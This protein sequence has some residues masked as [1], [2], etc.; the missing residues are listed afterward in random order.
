MGVPPGKAGV[1]HLEPKSR[2][3]SSYPT[4]PVDGNPGALQSVIETLGI[5]LLP[6]TFTNGNS[7]SSWQQWNPWRSAISGAFWLHRKTDGFP[8]TN[9]QPPQAECKLGGAGIARSWGTPSD[10]G[11]PRGA[12]GAI[13]FDWKTRRH[14]DRTE[15]SVPSE[16]G[17]I[18]RRSWPG[19]TR[20]TCDPRRILRIH[21]D[22]LWHF[23]EIEPPILLACRYENP[24]Q[25]FSLA[26]RPDK[27]PDPYHVRLQRVSRIPGTT[28]CVASFGAV[29][30]W[31]PSHRG[32]SATTPSCWT[33]GDVAR[34]ASPFVKNSN[35]MNIDSVWFLTIIMQWYIM[36]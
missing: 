36:L 9:A 16:P 26:W 27:T 24:E 22:F 18:G 11:S 8:P 1:A 32:F 7:F 6:T 21:M 29:W 15:T 4:W 31:E 14:E 10:L 28:T 12:V 25:R 2:Y 3:W 13:S 17:N 23:E 30:I 19:W 33:G 35:D 20:A 5:A 34:M